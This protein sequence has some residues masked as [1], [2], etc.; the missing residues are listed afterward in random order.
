MEIDSLSEQDSR[1]DA[2]ILAPSVYTEQMMVC[3]DV[4]DHWTLS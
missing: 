1:A 2:Y 4:F 3:G